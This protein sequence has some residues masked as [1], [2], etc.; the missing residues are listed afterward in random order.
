VRRTT[1]H[2]LEIV[3]LYAVLLL[4]V[5]VLALLADWEAIRS[6]F[7]NSEVGKQLWPELITVGARNTIVYTI[8]AFVGGLALAVVLALMRLSP[9][10]PYRWLATVYVEFF[11]GLPALLVIVIMGFAV[12]IAFHWR[13][14]GG[15]VGAGIVAL[16]LVAAA[17]MAETLRAGIQAVP[18]GQS[19]AARSLGMS[20]GRTTISVVLPQAFRVVIPPLTNEFVLLIKDT[21]LL[22]IIGVAAA[23]R[24]LTTYARDMNSLTAN[25]TPLIAAAVMYLII[26]LPL[27]QLVAALERKQQKAR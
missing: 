8:L 23:D 3:T 12:P 7:F 27:T 21:S 1:R 14:P 13:P 4:I 22:A 16:I 15:P 24:E 19:E 10:A 6:N 2:K 5:L 20:P 26:T 9:V 11:R 25:S 18:K 17:Y